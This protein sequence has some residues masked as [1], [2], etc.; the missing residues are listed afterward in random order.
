[1]TRRLMVILL[2]LGVLAQP[3]PARADGLFGIP[4]PG[5]PGVPNPIEIKLLKDIYDELVRERKDDDGLL[6]ILR[7]T[8]QFLQ[9]AFPSAKRVLAKVNERLDDVNDIREE[10]K[11][12]SCGWTFSV[13]DPFAAS[14]RLLD[15]RMWLCKPDIQRMFGQHS[16]GNIQL[17]GADLDEWYDYVTALNNNQ[18][19]ARAQNTNSSWYRVFEQGHAESARLRTSPGEA[20]RDTAIFM[21]MMHAVEVTNSQTAANALLVRQMDAAEDVRE[22]RANRQIAAWIIGTAEPPE[23]AR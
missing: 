23:T 19:S 10:V 13:N 11:R 16:V 15:K 22:E 9:R 7:R 4:I 6:G 12:L 5:F 1:M 3:G 20:E 2:A 21:A 8:D 14:R 18:L 17:P